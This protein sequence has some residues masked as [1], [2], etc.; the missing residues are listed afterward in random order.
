MLLSALSPLLR[1]SAPPAPRLLRSP[2]GGFSPGAQ[3]P[4]SREQTCARCCACQVAPRATATAGA[5]ARAPRLGR[6]AGGGGG[7]GRPGCVSSCARVRGAG[8][9]VGTGAL[10]ER[11]REARTRGSLGAAPPAALPRPRP[12]AAWG[13]WGGL[14]GTGR[15]PACCRRC[16]GWR[17]AWA[18]GVFVELLPGLGDRAAPRTDAPPE[19]GGLPARGWGCV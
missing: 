11:A 7:T 1:P 5:G 17:R 6:A 14:A 2:Q 16:R 3:A 19:H 9:K 12:G 10:A 8:G 13:V 4:G 18:A 15:A